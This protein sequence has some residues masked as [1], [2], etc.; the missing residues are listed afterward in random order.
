VIAEVM[1]AGVRLKCEITYL[2]DC[3]YRT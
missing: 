1:I 2:L 3:S